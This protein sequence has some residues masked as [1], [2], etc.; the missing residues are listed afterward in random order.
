[1]S[2]IANI[3]AAIVRR[4]TRGAAKTTSVEMGSRKISCRRNWPLPPRSPRSKPPEFGRTSR[5]CR[6]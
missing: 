3:E 1:M 2:S 6:G 5:I 4:R